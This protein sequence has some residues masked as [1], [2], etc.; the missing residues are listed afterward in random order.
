MMYLI[1]REE[2]FMQLCLEIGKERKFPQV[3]EMIEWRVNFALRHWIHYTEQS[4][5]AGLVNVLY[6]GALTPR[7]LR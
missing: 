6:S 1:V 7:K 5:T 2:Q 3:L 4:C